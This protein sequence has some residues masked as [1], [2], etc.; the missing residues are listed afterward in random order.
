MSTATQ[1]QAKLI[2][3][4][5]PE[6]N[7]TWW[8]E[9]YIDLPVQVTLRGVE[10]SVVVVGGPQSG[11]TIAIKAFERAEQ[12]RLFMVHYPVDRW[13][14]EVNAWLPGTENH[15]SQIMACAAVEVR[16][17]ISRHA[18]KLDD[19]KLTELNLE[20]LRW[21]IKKHSSKRT[22]SRWADSLTYEP[23]L[24]LMSE[25]FE[26]IYPDAT[27]LN[28]AQGQIEELVTLSRRLGFEG[29]A[30]LVDTTEADLNT[31]SRSDK[32]ADLFSWLI[33]LQF[34]GFAIKAAIPQAVVEQTNLLTIPRDRVTFA[35]LDWRL[36][37]CLKLADKSLT[38]A[39]SG[40]IKKF[41]ALANSPLQATIIDHLFTLYDH[42][43]PQI[44]TQLLEVLLQHVQQPGSP[45]GP[46]NADE[47]LHDYYAK[48]VPLKIDETAQGV[49]RGKTFLKLDPQPFGFLQILWH[50]RDSLDDP[51][52]ELLKLA[53]GSDKRGN[54][55]TIASRLRNKIEPVP[56]MPVYV[57]NNRIRGYWLENTIAI[58]T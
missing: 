33:P 51:D 52:R 38:V 46:D 17:F 7:I 45:L 56:K 20:Y 54:M 44:W 47:I 57:Q 2:T 16:N 11:K 27:V 30:V 3:A 53:G 31:D 29:I 14:G 48:Y 15:L 41:T 58:E 34:E 49:W 4:C 19:F 40:Q 50:Y 55:N 13:Y 28:D 42:M 23:L 25:P 21:L 24:Q 39:T 1:W 35:F 6:R 12:G 32:V 18:D 37:D 5:S 43:S 10:R 36:E 22:F 8:D 9:C 26:D